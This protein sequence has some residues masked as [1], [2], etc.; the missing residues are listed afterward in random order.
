MK[1]AGILL[2]LIAAPCSLCAA[3]AFDN[4]ADMGTFTSTPFTTGSYT[5]T[6][7]Y[8][9]LELDFGVV[10]AGGSGTAVSYGSTNLARLQAVSISGGDNLEL[11]G[12]ANPNTGA[13]TFTIT[14]TNSGGSPTGGAVAGSYSG[15]A[16][17]SSTTATGTFP[18]GQVQFPL[19]VT[20]V[21]A[22]AWIIEA[23]GGSLSNGTN[24]IVRATDSPKVL[25][26]ADAG[27]F[28]TPGSNTISLLSNFQGGNSYGALLAVLKPLVAATGQIRHEVTSQ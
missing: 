23:T 18:S 20:T 27:P 14:W 6:C 1:P 8:V 2:L 25:V 24:G 19:S 28:G 7:S 3:V 17:E 4:A 5:C 13:H 15:A 9:F 11:W 16:L 26:F 21:A 22:N 10:G 12:A